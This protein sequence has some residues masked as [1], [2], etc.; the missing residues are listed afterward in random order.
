MFKPLH[1]TGRKPA[2]LSQSEILNASTNHT[3]ARSRARS[4]DE[5]PNS[6]NFSLAEQS[7]S[8]K[9]SRSFPMQLQL[10]KSKIHRAAVTGGHVDYEGSMTIDADLMA[11]VGLVHHE[12]ILCGN[13]ADGSRFETYAIRGKPGSGAI[14]LNGA[15]ALLGKPGDLL[16]IMS[17]ANVNEADAANWE[18][19]VIVLGE[20]NTIVNERGL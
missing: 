17:F 12:K 8:V 1:R 20:K 9:A 5:F 3:L 13:M 10:L 14:V 18:P 16:T 7:S 15:C 2:L 11:K 4:A 19:K 6:D